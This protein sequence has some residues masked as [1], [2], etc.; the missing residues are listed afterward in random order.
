LLELYAKRFVP[1]FNCI[2]VDPFNFT[3]FRPWVTKHDLTGWCQVAIENRLIAFKPDASTI[4]RH[5]A[6]G[7]KGWSPAEL[8]TGPMVPGAGD[9][10]A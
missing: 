4:N 3:Y 6:G 10:I 9:Q 7:M 2:V 5:D 8:T 1:D